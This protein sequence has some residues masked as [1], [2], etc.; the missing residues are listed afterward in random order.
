M[1]A[2][3]TGQLLDGHLIGEFVGGGAMG[4]VYK[5]THPEWHEPVAI[6]ILRKE[7]ASD[8]NFRLRFEREARL[9]SSLSHRHIIPILKYG[10]AGDYL[11]FT[12]KF[13]NGHTLYH[14]MLAERYTPLSAWEILRPVCEAL[15]YGH[16][17]GIIHRDVKPGNVFLEETHGQLHVYLGDYG[18]G[19]APAIDDTLTHFGVPIGTPEYM[20]PE[21]AMGDKPDYRADIYSLCVVTYEMLLGRLPFNVPENHPKVLAHVNFSPLPPSFFR[22]DFPRALEQAIM[23]GMEKYKEKRHNSVMEFGNQYYQTLLMMT[24]T[25]RNTE[26]YYLNTQTY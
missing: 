22:P 6:K 25:E 24:D 26:Y 15:A 16:A 12:M 21:A 7:F 14:E 10:K 2:L 19:K 20:S 11:Y 8:S 18:L 1:E 3:L 4:E 23:Q 5:A 17:Q 9:M 13:I